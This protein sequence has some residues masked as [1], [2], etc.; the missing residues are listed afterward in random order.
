MPDSEPS[1]RNWRCLWRREFGC[2]CVYLAIAIYASW[3]LCLAPT[4]T[5]SIGFENDATVPLL[6]V[7][8]LWW[9]ADR[10]AAGFR[11]YWDAPIFY[12]TTG[13]FA[14]SEAQPTMALMSP[15]VW[16]TGSRIL[17]YNVY[18]LLILSLNGY[19][20]RCLFRRVGHQSWL[21]FIGGV[22]CEMLPFIWWQSG[23][24]QLTTLFGIVWTIHALLDVFDLPTLRNEADTDLTISVL[25][26]VL[27]GLRLGGAFCLTYLMCNYWGLF[28]TLLLVPSSVWFWNFNLLRLRFWIPLVV[29]GLFSALL[30]WPLVTVQRS[31]AAEHQW[32]RDQNWILELSAHARDFVDTP[33]TPPS[34]E[35]TIPTA[36]AA[37]DNNDKADDP[38]APVVWS[39]APQLEFPEASRENVWPLGGG[40]L[41]LLLVPVGLVASLFVRGRRRWGL[42]AAT[43]ALIAFGLSLGP[44]VMIHPSVPG[45]GGKIPYEL[46]QQYT[47][48]FKLIRSPFRFAFF[49]QLAV[50]WL[51]VEAFD[52]L[53]PWR[54]WKRP[55][56]RPP[57]VPLEEFDPAADP[58]MPYVHPVLRNPPPSIFPMVQQCG[59]LGLLILSS[60]A[61]VVEV[62]PPRQSM[63]H[64]QSLGTPSWIMWLREN[65]QPD[66]VVV[67]LPF[68]TGSTVGDYQ[69]TSLWMYWGTLHGRRL[70]NG[71]SGF[72]P[73]HFVDL[74]EKLQRDGTQLKMF[75]WDSQGLKDLNVCQARFVVVKRSFATRDDV[76]QHPLTKFRWAWLTADEE[77]QL[78]VYEI[79]PV[80]PD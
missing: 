16:L 46:L 32:S 28:L 47:P 80:D 44:A 78:D 22:L 17:A 64:H 21:A 74:K 48:G 33:A 8:T 41:K 42:F 36:A 7:W 23:V 56:T 18:L 4:S 55:F 59:M 35:R 51:N 49:V 75:P 39:W 60:L 15:I 20:S 43:F 26:L 12:P 72:F 29:G 68:P 63:Y 50:V 62:W 25:Q 31:L 2:W 13:T 57:D 30:L 3:P 69:E 61:L 45:V 9:N 73:R 66:E 79:E 1:R 38:P 40:T 71:Y 14:F 34:H 27:R 70:V 19:S 67:C 37:A 11:G 10:S 54:W 53:N 58:A 65:S 52:L 76:W 77:H 6:N 24:V 5:I